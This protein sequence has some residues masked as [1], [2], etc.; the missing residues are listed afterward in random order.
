MGELPSVEAM[1]G[2]ISVGRPCTGC[3]CAL[4]FVIFQYDYMGADKYVVTTKMVQLFSYVNSVSAFSWVR[5]VLQRDGKGPAP[6]ESGEQR[7]P[8]QPQFLPLSRCSLAST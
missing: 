2:G 4:Q 5:K 6:K 3:S 7:C 8:D 1:R